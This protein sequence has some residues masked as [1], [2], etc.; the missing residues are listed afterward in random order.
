MF[1]PLVPIVCC[2]AAAAL[3]LP[4]PVGA[5]CQTSTPTSVTFADHPADGDLN[6]APEIGLVSAGVDG[7]CGY[8]VDPGVSPPFLVEDDAVFIYLD[9]DGNPATGDPVFT[10]A[11]AVVG[12]IGTAGGVTP[13]RLARWTGATYDFTGG[14]DLATPTAGGFRASIDQ[15]GVPSGVTTRFR[16]GT[17]WSGTYDN[18]FD[19]APD[20]PG[21]AIAL[22]VV[23]G[24]AAPIPAPAPPPPP[25]PAP[26]PAPPAGAADE[27]VDQTS[28]RVP[29]VRGLSVT[30]A[31]D[32]LVAA[33]CEL[34]STD[35]VRFHTKVRR[36]R[37][38]ATNPAAGRRT[39][40]PVRLIVSKGRKPRRKRRSAA[41]A[42]AASLS[43]LARAE[44][45][46][47]LGGPVTPR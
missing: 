25:A 37:V 5:A 34:A 11:D 7:G 21:S 36:G 39:S 40:R 29:R 10:G 16:V 2:A 27:A 24:T 17:M 42:T 46:V 12:T 26:A 14:A 19:F 22:P 41:R 35:R 43:A 47:R 31:E 30:R 32:K 8:A 13:P 15:L 44:R 9:T 28:C 3:A 18:Y 20:T 33:G 23:F 4:A 45:R 6:L 1:R 38:I